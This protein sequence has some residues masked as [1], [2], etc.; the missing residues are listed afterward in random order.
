MKNQKC[1]LECGAKIPLARQKVLP[2]TEL[3]LKC[4]AIREERDG[5]EA[6]HP[7]IQYDTEEMIRT[8][9]SDD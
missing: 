3:C 9:S 8:I 5:I 2:D 6:N 4:A 1:C 7:T